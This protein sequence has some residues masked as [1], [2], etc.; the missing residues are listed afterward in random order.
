[1]GGDRR[2]GIFCDDYGYDLGVR[3]ARQN[4]VLDYIHGKASAR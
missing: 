2:K 3:R 4:S 1:V